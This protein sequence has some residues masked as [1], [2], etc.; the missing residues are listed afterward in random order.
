MQM[1]QLKINHADVIVSA[2]PL[3][4]FEKE[5]AVRII[6]S[7]YEALRRGGVFVQFNYS[8]L[9]KKIYQRVFDRV[10]V[11]FVLGNLPPAFVFRCK[12]LK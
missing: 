1:L 11:K 7:C 12:K 8:Y 4:L 6:H 2:L 9:N 5:L 3:V 10:R